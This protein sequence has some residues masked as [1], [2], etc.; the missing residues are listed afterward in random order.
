[1]KF[2]GRKLNTMGLQNI[3]MESYI[4]TAFVG[5]GAN[6]KSSQQKLT[7]R[8]QGGTGENIMLSTVLT[9]NLVLFSEGLIFFM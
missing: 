6:Q 5:W 2:V 3:L 7:A 4:T 8:L 9:G 1:M